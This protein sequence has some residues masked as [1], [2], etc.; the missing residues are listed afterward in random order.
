MRQRTHFDVREHKVPACHIREYAGSTAASQEEVLYLHVKQYTPLPALSGAQEK[1]ALT[2]IATNGV[3]LSKELYEPLWDEIYQLSASN[4]YAIRGIW[5]ADAVSLGMSGVLNEGKLSNDYSW[6]DHARDLLLMINQFRDQ[7]P[8][9]LVGIGHSFGGCQITNLAYLHPRLFASMILLDPVIQLSPPV[10]GFNGLPTGPVNFT[11]HRK[12]LWPN[13]AAA[14]QKRASKGWDPR[15]LERMM[16][17]GYRDLPTALYPDLPPDADRSDPPVT[18]TTTKHQEALAQLRANFEA[19]QPDGRIHINRNTHAD[20]DPLSAFVPLYRPEL[21]STFHRL[22]GLRP[23]TLWVVGEKTFLCLD[24]IREG[25]KI[26]G[27]GVG[28]SGGSPEAKV[29][30]VMTFR[31]QQVKWNQERENMTMKDHM[32]L[33]KTWMEVVKPPSGVKTKLQAY[34][35]Y[36]SQ[37]VEPQGSRD[38]QV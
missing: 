28:G 22:P 13:R 27:T 1:D 15:V 17:Y 21:R 19:R 20:M 33:S 29:K 34:N 7:M 6:M 14:S 4:D 12:D 32:T 37:V 38:A 8:R 16:Q 31:E 26:A 25:I 35:L 5:I 36:Q 3:G 11:T 10:M 30:E 24:E 9:P 18:L 23:P 2:I